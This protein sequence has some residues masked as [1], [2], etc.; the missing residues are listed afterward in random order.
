[1]GQKSS[2]AKKVDPIVREST[3][4][5]IR[6]FSINQVLNQVMRDSEI[7]RILVAT[8]MV[9]PNL[10]LNLIVKDAIKNRIVV[11]LHRKKTC[12]V[13]G[14]KI[15]L[16]IY[17][18]YGLSPTLRLWQPLHSMGIAEL[19]LCLDWRQKNVAHEMVQIHAREW[20]IRKMI[21]MD[22]GTVGEVLAV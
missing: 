9:E 10:N 1:M 22:A 16:R 6:P 19:Q 5:R 12:L 18:N 15:A 20:I 7:S 13:D 11:E 3:R 17:E 4:P 21:E 8:Y 2:F 14:D